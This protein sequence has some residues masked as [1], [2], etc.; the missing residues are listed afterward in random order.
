MPADL[1][2]IHNRLRDMGEELADLAMARLQEAI[3][4]TGPE[5]AAAVAEERRLTRARRAI[6][7][8]V[9]ILGP[10]GDLDDG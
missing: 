4:G 9:A 5:A 3:G 2:D 6:E 10:P 8:A 1:E 7:R